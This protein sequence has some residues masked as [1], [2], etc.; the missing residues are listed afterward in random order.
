M[1]I[2]VKAKA[3]AKENKV[4]VPQP[5]LLSTDGE[6]EYYV[7]YVKEPPKE[8][9]ANEAI[10][11]SLADYFGVGKSDIKLVSGATSKIKVFDINTD[12]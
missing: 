2:F 6:K 7:V 11:K 5:R 8:G 1:K 4:I 12:E 3:G 9:R 10:I